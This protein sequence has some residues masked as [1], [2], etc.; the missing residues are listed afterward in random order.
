MIKSLFLIPYFRSESKE[1][2][3]QEP[4]SKVNKAIYSLF[5][6]ALLI[7]F[8]HIN[9]YGLMALMIASIFMLYLSLDINKSKKIIGLI[10]I[11]G[12]ISLNYLFFDVFADFLHKYSIL[13]SIAYSPL[14]MLLIVLFSHIFLFLKKDI[15][16]KKFHFYSEIK[17]IEVLRSFRV[18]TT[19]TLI[20]PIIPYF[21]LLTGEIELRKI[22]VEKVKER[23][24]KLIE[25]VKQEKLIEKTMMLSLAKG[26]VLKDL[27]GKVWNSPQG[28]FKAI[29]KGG[30]IYVKIN[31]EV[32]IIVDSI[33]N[34]AKFDNKIKQIE[35]TREQQIYFI[36]NRPY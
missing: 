33:K 30:I 2:L 24:I 8:L 5:L 22:Q 6:V 34:K 12:V 36:V 35:K 1:Q 10:V 23:S 32:Y 14:Y 7:P 13:V 27:K 11:V 29:Q 19:L 4:I 20:V 9:M 26:T 21:I 3:D 16:Y 17:N 18:I 31:N 15:F 28:T 25:G